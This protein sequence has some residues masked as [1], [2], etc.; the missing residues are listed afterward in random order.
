MANCCTFQMRVRGEKDNCESFINALKQKGIYWIGRGASVSEEL[1]D[2]NDNQYLYSLIGEC[3]WSLFS[4]LYDDAVSMQ[5]APERWDI[6]DR[7][8][9]KKIIPI[10]YKE[11]CDMFNVEIEAWSDE[12]GMEFAEYL[13]YEKDKIDKLECYDYEE[14]E[15]EE[16]EYVIVEEP[17]GFYEFEL[18]EVEHDI[19]TEIN[20]R[21]I[22]QR[23]TR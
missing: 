8:K 23:K 2:S 9:N 7:L 4:A 19:Q 14:K 18:S 10:T 5:I 21:F 13:R 11:A 20:N 22:P 16:G 17:E 6:N 3:K 1:L 12:C 15:N